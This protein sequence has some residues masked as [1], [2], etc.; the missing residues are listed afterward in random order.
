MSLSR[1]RRGFAS[2][3]PDWKFCPWATKATAE[4]APCIFLEIKE[5]YSLSQ[6]IKQKRPL[7]SL[8]RVGQW[9]SQ[10][11]L[12][13]GALSAGHPP[14]TARRRQEPLLLSST[15]QD[16][17]GHPKDEDKRTH[18]VTSSTSKIGS[19]SMATISFGHLGDLVL[20]A[21]AC[22]ACTQSKLWAALRPT[23]EALE[24]LQHVS[25]PLV[26]K[27]RRSG[28]ETTSP[29]SIS[30]SG[31]SLILPEGSNKL[32]CCGWDGQWLLWGAEE[33]GVLLSASACTNARWFC[34]EPLSEWPLSGQ[35][36]ECDLKM[37]RAVL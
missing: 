13:P 5:N 32:L 28:M 20:Q 1:K 31:L 11:T 19:K 10:G 4:T 18:P 36:S 34:M 25:H 26:S 12:P 14:L 6:S 30:M 21:A 35:L 16:Q 23:R 7:C 9:S 8:T 29:D 37:Y 2:L 22:P 15:D 33:A 17:F 27:T 3:T 24:E